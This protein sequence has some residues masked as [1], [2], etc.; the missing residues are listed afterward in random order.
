MPW[1]AITNKLAFPATTHSEVPIYLT[2]RVYESG[3]TGHSL[4]KKGGGGEG[5]D[6][7]RNNHLN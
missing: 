2:V 4:N 6:T 7:E 1:Y 5:R 3:V